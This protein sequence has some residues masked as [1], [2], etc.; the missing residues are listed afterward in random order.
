[1]PQ[2]VRLLS[3]IFPDRPKRAIGKHLFSGGHSVSML[4]KAATLS[5]EQDA[6]DPQVIHVGITNDGTG[7]SFPTGYG[8]RA[9]LLYVDISGPDAK[10]LK[11]ADQKTS[12]ATYTVDPGLSPNSEKVH[13][14]IRAGTTAKVTLKLDSQPG[15]YRVNARLFYDLDRLDDYND[16][17]LPLIAAVELRVKLGD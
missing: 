13:P 2:D 4:K 16:K 3:E 15:V 7:H 1:M 9:V 17:S 10:A 8:P 6:S 14:A 5:V 11:G 12:V